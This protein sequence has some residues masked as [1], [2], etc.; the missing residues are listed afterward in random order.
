VYVPAAPNVTT[1]RFGCGEAESLS[2]NPAFKNPLP[3][4]VGVRAGSEGGGSL[5]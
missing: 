3:W 1:A 4:F 2:S 5:G